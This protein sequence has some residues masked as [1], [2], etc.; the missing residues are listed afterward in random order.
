MPNFL[1]KMFAHSFPPCKD[2]TGST[3][4]NRER[5]WE[6]TGNL[7]MECENQGNIFPVIE[8]ERWYQFA[9]D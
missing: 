1:P 8:R 9:E 6:I 2:G 7:D 5:F 4:N 3:G